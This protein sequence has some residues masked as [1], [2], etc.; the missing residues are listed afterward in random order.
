[1]WKILKGAKMNDTQMEQFN[2]LE[3]KVD[4]YFYLEKTALEL[5]AMM[6][7]FSIWLALIFVINNFTN[8]FITWFIIVLELFAFIGI[9]AFYYRRKNI[10]NNVKELFAIT[11]EKME[12]SE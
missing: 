5:I 6:G 3:E 11:K 2:Q 9:V 1:M 12:Q 4:I 8:D 7:V 10:Q